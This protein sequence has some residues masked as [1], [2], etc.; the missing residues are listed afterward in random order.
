[1]PISMA[2]KPTSLPLKA[3]YADATHIDTF[4]AD[5]LLSVFN[6]Y[7][8]PNV[9]TVQFRLRKIGNDGDDVTNRDKELLIIVRRMFVLISESSVSADIT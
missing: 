6:I 2:L 7:H 3:K 5:R 8:Q 4:V 9:I 1:V